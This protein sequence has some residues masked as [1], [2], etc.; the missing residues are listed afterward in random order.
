M[1]KKQDGER[2]TQKLP[3]WKPAISQSIHIDKKK[4]SLSNHKSL[5]KLKTLPRFWECVLTFLRKCLVL[6]VCAKKIIFR[7]VHI[8]LRSLHFSTSVW[9]KSVK[10]VGGQLGRGQYFQ[11]GWTSIAG[12]SSTEISLT[13]GI[14][15]ILD[16]DFFSLELSSSPLLKARLSFHFLLFSF[17]YR[18]H[19]LKRCL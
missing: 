15:F 1:N 16:L 5:C 9:G 14:L 3:L 7:C 10:C 13:T 18:F 12:L 19:N 17:S 2:S 4:T 11:Q 8:G 6:K